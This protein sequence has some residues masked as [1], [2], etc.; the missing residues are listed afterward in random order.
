MLQNDDAVMSDVVEVFLGLMPLFTYEKMAMFN[1]I[2]QNKAKSC[3]E[4]RKS[5][6]FITGYHYLTH[7]L[8]PRYKGEIFKSQENIIIKVYQ[9]LEKYANENGFNVD[10]HSEIAT[11]L[12]EF[13]EKTSYFSLSILNDKNPRRFWNN[14]KMIDGTKKLATIASRLFSVPCSSASCER[15]FST[16]KRLYTKDRN[17]LKE[18]KIHKLMLIKNYLAEQVRKH[19]KPKYSSKTR[20]SQSTCQLEEITDELEDLE[21]EE[22]QAYD[23]DEL[24]YLDE[25]FNKVELETLEM[26][27]PLNEFDLTKD[28]D[29]QC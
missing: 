26:E 15:S 4:N 6:N 16:Q 10:D 27:E 17:R 1:V 20:N 29:G 13:K 23:I 12:G 18:E 2:E 19:E 24:I 5:A 14:Y 7:M 3:Y 9:T 22:G 8:D 21:L 25:P 11:C 28:G